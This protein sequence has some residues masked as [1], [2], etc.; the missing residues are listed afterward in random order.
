MANYARMFFLSAD[1]MI[2]HQVQTDTGV[3]MP[4]LDW[5]KDNLE[6]GNEGEQ[7][8]AYYLFDKMPGMTRVMDFRNEGV[9]DEC[10][11]ILGRD[12]PES[13]RA[14]LPDMSPLDLDMEA[15]AIVDAILKAD[16]DQREHF[17]ASWSSPLRV[18][19][20]SGWQFWLPED[21]AF[22]LQ[23]YERLAPH[24]ELL[25]ESEWEWNDIAAAHRNQSY[26]VAIVLYEG[27]AY[28]G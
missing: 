9:F 3:S 18:L 25:Q 11:D 5:I 19:N 17:L 12:A 24:E 14:R 6:R 28:Y 7:K 15:D 26:D 10:L 16:K 23:A 22:F 8:V 20:M 21:I 4:L 27:N 1:E 13:M 2:A